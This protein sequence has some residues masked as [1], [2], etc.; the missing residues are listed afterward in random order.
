MLRF[1]YFLL[2]FLYFSKTFSA[3]VT[4]PSTFTTDASDWI[5]VSNSGTTPA[6]S[7]FTNA[8]VIIEASVGNIKITTTSGLKAISSYC[9][10]AASDERSESEPTNCNGGSLTELGFSGTQSNINSALESLRFKGNSGTITI[11][12]Y[13]TASGVKYSKS[14]EHFY[15]VV[16][17]ATNDNYEGANG[18]RAK[19]L[20]SSYNGLDGYLCNVNSQAENDFLEDLFVNHDTTPGAH[21]HQ[22]MW[23]GGYAASGETNTW[24]DGPDAGTSIPTSG[25]EYFNNW[26]SGEPNNTAEDYVVMYYKVGKRGKWNDTNNTALDAADHYCIEYDHTD[27]L[28]TSSYATASITLTSTTS[29][30]SSTKAII[31]SQT[32]TSSYLIRQ[33]ISNIQDRMQFTRNLDK[34]ISNQNIKL[35]LNIESEKKKQILNNLNS[36]FFNKDK[37]LFDNFAIWTKGNLGNGKIKLSNDILNEDI[38]NSNS[39]TIGVDSKLEKN[40]SL[41]L[42]LTLI[43]RDS[44]I[45]SDKA[46]IDANSFNIASYASMM[47]DEK[48]WIDFLIGLGKIEFDIDR[49]VS[50]SFNNGSRDGKQIFS[51]FKYTKKHKKNF[52]KNISIYSKFDLGFTQLD[53]YTET[54]S[55]ELIY[56]NKQY[57]KQATLGIGSNVSKVVNFK[58]GFFIPFVNFEAGGNIANISDAESSYTTSSSVSSYKIKNDNTSFCKLNI[59]FEADLYDNW[60]I[61]FSYDYYE[62]MT[63]E[64]NRENQIQ[65]TVVKKLM[66]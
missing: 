47:L 29:L 31:R 49:K 45:G 35:A 37:N 38:Y 18:A 27:T 61:K 42:A 36:Y 3:N 2:F 60:E 44:E 34:N 62:E 20:A 16:S 4:L 24:R 33:S 41:G 5:Q 26:N 32:I 58:D 25:S 19:A 56:Y 55:S 7:G 50:S 28:S 59:G 54:G 10:Y 52:K 21:A 11:K 30:D 48:E 64:N 15:N 63:S 1:I 14:T 39:L 65:F 66:N 23:L 51:S 17:D 53:S 46:Y 9:G 13:E 22:S 8:F 12:A 6:I 43:S 40:N 57:I